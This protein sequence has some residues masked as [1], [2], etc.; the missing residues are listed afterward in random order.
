MTRNKITDTFLKRN[1][2]K[3]HY[4]TILS[5]KGKCVEGY[6][7]R[8]LDHQDI[9][10]IVSFL[11]QHPE[12]I[13]LDLSYNNI[14]DTGFSL[15]CSRINKSALLILNLNN[16]DLNNLSREGCELLGENKILKRLCLSGNSLSFVTSEYLKATLS[17]NTT[18]EVL[19]LNGVDYFLHCFRR[20]LESLIEGN[21]TTLKVLDMSRLI[22]RPLYNFDSPYLAEI[23]YT[24]LLGNDTLQELHLEKNE[25]K[26]H[27][28]EQ[29]SVALK[30]NRS[31]RILNLTANNITS[32]GLEIISSV[33]HQSNLEV[34]LL[35]SNSIGDDG[36]IALSKT[37]PLSKIL[38][39]DLSNNRIEDVGIANLLWTII[40]IYTFYI[41]GNPF[42]KMILEIIHVQMLRG[43]VSPESLDIVL[44][45]DE[46]SNLRYSQNHD[47]YN[48]RTHIYNMKDTLL[49]SRGTDMSLVYPS[50]DIFC[51]FRSLRR[52]QKPFPE[53]EDQKMCYM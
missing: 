36:A 20:I 37:M 44:Y 33:L 18:L 32:I 26:D 13:S 17:V 23:V 9:P 51:P 30:N 10:Q 52:N 25:L 5:L 3:L 45:W 48:F 2:R 24:L 14:D 35:R 49:R 34:L 11:D 28:L 47:A 39:I 6:L 7:Q 42:T 15:L 46:E 31:L 41:F 27:D 40:P 4:G 38:H 16:N 21:N 22:G 19:E 29:I 12:I 50:Y 53:I 8:R 1:S 43:K